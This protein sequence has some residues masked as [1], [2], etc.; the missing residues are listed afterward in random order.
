MCQFKITFYPCGLP[1]VRGSWYKLCAGRPDCAKTIEM[2]QWNTL[3]PRMRKCLASAWNQQRPEAERHRWSPELAKR[4]ACCKAL[5]AEEFEALCRKCNPAGALQPGGFHRCSPACQ[6][7]QFT[8]DDPQYAFE[9]YIEK[10]WPHMNVA[11]Y[12]QR[13][14]ARD[15]TESEMWASSFLDK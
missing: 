13:R 6:V 1:F 5:K 14:D 2:L 3:C 12:E 7:E 8:T 11:R 10:Y 9:W 4:V 15:P